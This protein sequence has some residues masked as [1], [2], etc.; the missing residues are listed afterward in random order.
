V[1]RVAEHLVFAYGSNLDGRQMR[2]RC[3]SARRAGKAELRG[4]RVGFAG[5]SGAWRGAVATLLD[6]PGHR[7]QGTLWRM[8]DDDM[9]MLDLY[10]GVPRQYGRIAVPVR[11]TSG[12]KKGRKA[13]AWTYVQPPRQPAL[14]SRDYLVRIADAY[15][16]LGFDSR[17]LFDALRDA[18]LRSGAV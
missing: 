13:H 9:D 11:R 1:S 5:W 8:D 17:P 7:V 14:P 10:E 15:R 4:F 16:E 2:E 18:G 3:P 6:A 12:K